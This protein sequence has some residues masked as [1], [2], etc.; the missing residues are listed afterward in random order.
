[1]RVAERETGIR[2]I[3]VVL[4]EKEKPLAVLFGSIR[5]KNNGCK[6]NTKMA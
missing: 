2:N 4:G 1:M 3:D 6:R 5:R